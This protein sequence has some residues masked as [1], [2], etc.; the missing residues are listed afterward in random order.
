MFH[1]LNAHVE[2]YKHSHEVSYIQA[3]MKDQVLQTLVFLGR[4]KMY[5][6]T[7]TNALKYNLPG[8]ITVFLRTD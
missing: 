1:I 8:G 3:S 6:S 2:L 4:G 5:H 7:S